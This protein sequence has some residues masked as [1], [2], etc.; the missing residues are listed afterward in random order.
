[1]V[2]GNCVF[3]RIIGGDEMVSIVH[4]DD[5]AIAFMDVQPLSPGHTLIVS[6]DH[7]PTIFDVPDDVAAHCIAVAKQIV[8]GIRRATGADA[9]NLLSGNGA[10]GSQD[11][12]HF[13]LHLIP[14][15]SGRPFSLQLAAEDVAIPTRSEL[16]VMAARIGRAIQDRH[17]GGVARPTG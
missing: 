10:A 1:M 2:D 3:C 12:A 16:D 5:R 17:T 14:V 13:H 4:E 7:Y 11:V 6:R 8:P 9:I 15:S